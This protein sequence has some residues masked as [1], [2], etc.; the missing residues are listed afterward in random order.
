MSQDPKHQD[1]RA[2]WLWVVAFAAFSAFM[3]V[4]PYLFGLNHDSQYL[5]N[6]MPI[7]ALGLFAGS[8]FRSPW[9]YGVPLA[10]MMASDL[11]LIKPL[12]DLGMSAFTLLTPVVYLSFGLN[13]C[14]GR[15]LRP[16]AFVGW[17]VPLALLCG[18]QFFLT[19]NIAVWLMGDGVM[20]PRTLAGLELC[21]WEGWKFDRNTLSANLLYSAVFFGLHSVALY[22]FQPQRASQ[23]A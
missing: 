7:G 14:I 2:N 11:L 20:Y 1:W 19:T 17:V 12:S 9:A 21:L 15:I 5:W 16:N 4:V 13:V 22:L 6:L 8:R 3:R 10:A 23:P 18:L